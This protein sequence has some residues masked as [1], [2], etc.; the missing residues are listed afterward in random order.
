MSEADASPMIVPAYTSNCRARWPALVIHCSAL[1]FP[2]ARPQ[3]PCWATPCLRKVC[4]SS[5]ELQHYEFQS[6]CSLYTSVILLEDL[7]LWGWGWW[8]SWCP[9]RI[10]IALRRYM[11]GICMCMLKC[12]AS[13]SMLYF[14]WEVTEEGFPEVPK[15]YSLT[16]CPLCPRLIDTGCWSEHWYFRNQQN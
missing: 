15:G 7:W 1:T 6:H 10:S 9:W 14:E 4:Y 11:M 8:G 5:S 13:T 3:E 2:P 16:Y 12:G